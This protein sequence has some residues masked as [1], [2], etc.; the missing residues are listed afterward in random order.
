MSFHGAFLKRSLSSA[1]GSGVTTSN[2]VSIALW[3]EPCSVACVPHLTTDVASSSEANTKSIVVSQSPLLH[4]FVP[5]GSRLHS[6]CSLISS[7]IGSASPCLPAETSSPPHSWS[8]RLKSPE[9][10]TSTRV[11]TRF[12]VSRMSWSSLLTACKSASSFCPST[13]TD[14]TRTDWSGSRSTAAVMSDDCTGTCSASMSLR[15]HNMLR[16]AHLPCRCTLG[17][18][19]VQFEWPVGAVTTVFSIVR[20]YGSDI[21]NTP[22]SF[23]D[24]SFIKLCCTI[25]CFRTFSWRIRSVLLILGGIEHSALPTE[26][27]VWPTTGDALW[28][29]RLALAVVVSY[30]CAF[31]TDLR[32]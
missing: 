20:T 12:R 22:K 19:F 25:C 28:D 18:I 13:Y 15:T 23:R 7:M 17:T 4:V 6:P 1:T 30:R 8:C 5:R 21:A 24:S 26:R 10:N 14:P 9:S 27:F 2:I 32:L 16:N 31:R 3:S 11:P 29:R